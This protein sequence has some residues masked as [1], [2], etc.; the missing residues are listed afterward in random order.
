MTAAPVVVGMCC[1]PFGQKTVVACQL[2]RG[3]LLLRT[4]SIQLAAPYHEQ[5]GGC[6]QFAQTWPTFWQLQHCLMAF[7][8]SY[9]GNVAESVWRFLEMFL[10]EQYE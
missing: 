8:D 2:W 10:F 7:R 9:D 5:R 3:V 4:A 1:L 6:L